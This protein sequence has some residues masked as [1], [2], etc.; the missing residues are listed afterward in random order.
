MPPEI[1]VSVRELAWGPRSPS[2]NYPFLC[3]LRVYFDES[4][5]H[6][7]RFCVVAGFIG[8]EDQW[9]EFEKSWLVALAPRKHLHMN[10]LRWTKPRTARL[11][12]R[13]GPVPHK[14]GLM[15]VVG[16]V[17]HSAYAAAIA[18]TMPFLKP[19]LLCV[20]MC[21]RDILRWLPPYETIKFVFE[22]QTEYE[23]HVQMLYSAML[24][25][26]ATEPRFVGL[27]FVRK[28]A[29]YCTEPAD[30]LAF[31]WREFCANKDSHKATLGLSIMG[32]E[33]T[34]MLGDI[35]TRDE[36]RGFADQ[37]AA[38]MKSL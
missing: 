38:K 36:L 27:E 3:M 14:H 15:P 17:T 5:H 10:G 8:N 21:A 32:N 16:V 25:L 24:A 20:G 9:T 13:L 31:Q 6:G 1:R 12:A 26:G 37:V 2:R 7:G 11:L 23:R 18:P 29:T 33:N 4:G 34:R 19:W 22:Q 30:Y 35:W 28:Q